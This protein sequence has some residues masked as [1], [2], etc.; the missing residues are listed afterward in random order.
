MTYFTTPNN[1]AVWSPSSIAWGQALPW[2]E[3]DNNVS[4]VMSN[5]LD[6]FAKPGPLPGHEYDAEEKHW[7]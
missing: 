2:N 1:G 7:R 3:T 4:V 5:V 6:A